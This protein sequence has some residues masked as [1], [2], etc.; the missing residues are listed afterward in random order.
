[1]DFSFR[2]ADGAEDSR[3]GAAPADVAF[4]GTENFRI[5]GIRI[6]A[7]ERR[8]GEDHARCTVTALHRIGLDESLLERVETAV[9]GESF[10]GR[11][12]LALGDS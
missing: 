5:A 4:H 7:E 11:N 3:I 12:L 8:G 2:R 10:D 1:M 6:L 9:N